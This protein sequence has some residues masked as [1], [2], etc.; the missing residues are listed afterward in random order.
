MAISQRY[1]RSSRRSCPKPAGLALQTKQPE[2]GWGSAAKAAML[3]NIRAQLWQARQRADAIGAELRSLDVGLLWLKQVDQC[4][5]L[6]DQTLVL[7]AVRSRTDAAA[8]AGTRAT[9]T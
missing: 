9:E 4:T 6:G 8:E 2:S 3:E 5:R 7:Q 1:P